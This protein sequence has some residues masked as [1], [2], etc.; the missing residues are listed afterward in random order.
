MLSMTATYVEELV[1]SVILKVLVDALN[2]VE[3]FGADTDLF[4]LAHYLVHGL[5]I[6]GSCSLSAHA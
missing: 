6:S 3:V 2:V 1:D 5:L 4:H